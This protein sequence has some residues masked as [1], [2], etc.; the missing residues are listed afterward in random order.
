MINIQKVTKARL[1]SAIWKMWLH[2]ERTSCNNTSLE[3][4]KSEKEIMVH[5]LLRC[6]RYSTY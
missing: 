2:K 4:Q 3:S 6:H 5:A 1:G